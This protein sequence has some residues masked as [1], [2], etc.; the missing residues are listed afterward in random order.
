MPCLRCTRLSGVRLVMRSS[1]RD[2]RQAPFRLRDTMT[3]HCRARS[4]CLF[5]PFLQNLE[6]LSVEKVG[7]A[8]RK[9][10]VP[11]LGPLDDPAGVIYLDGNLTE[12]TVDSRVLDTVG[13]GIQQA[14]KE[15][16]DLGTRRRTLVEEIRAQ[17]R[18]VWTIEPVQEA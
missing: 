16:F 11:P 6:Q 14:R 13:E 12:K 3:N 7:D 5:N 2:P 1:L 17:K 15:L 18:R 10:Y 4:S 9:L 8:F